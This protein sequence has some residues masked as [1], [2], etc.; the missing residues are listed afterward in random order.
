MW[1]YV[2]DNLLPIMLSQAAVD[3][4]GEKYAHHLAIVAVEIA[5]LQEQ[6]ATQNLPVETTEDDSSQ[7]NPSNHTID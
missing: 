3:A 1:H 5:A 2:E 6:A 4:K 7:Y